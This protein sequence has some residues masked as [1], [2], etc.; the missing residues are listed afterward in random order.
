MS[1]HEKI[2]DVEVFRITNPS[3]Q[4][5][6]IKITTDEG[7]IGLGDCGVSY[8]VGAASMAHLIGEL[9]QKY[10]LGRR[11]RE[12]GLISMEMTYN[13]FW[14][15]R[16][17]SL[18]SG[19][20][21]ALDQ[22]VHDAAARS[23]GVPL[24]ELLGGAVRERVDVYANGW[25]FGQPDEA[26]QMQGALRAVEDGHTGLK[27][28][29]FA[30]QDGHQRLIHPL[31]SSF[32]RKLIEESVGRVE[33][34]R[35]TVGDEVQIMVDLSG[36]MP[37]D[38]SVNV[39]QEFADLGV[40]FAEEPFNPSDDPSHRWLAGRS[41]LPIAAGERFCG[42]AAFER[43]IESGGVDI[44]Q[45]D[46]S[47][48]GGHRIFQAVADLALNRSVRVSPHNCSSGIST[49]HTLQ[50]VATVSNLHSVE[51]FPYLDSDPNYV[52]IL[53]DPLELRI[54]AGSLAI[55]QSPG[56]GVDFD[57]KRV[58]PYRVLHLRA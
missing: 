41:P 33:A 40:D 53:S 11:L 34:L 35:S 6:V 21:S 46:I 15:K 56:I 57:E 7:T 19:A 44:L 2:I 37:R 17:G 27:L 49:A 26:A 38:I 36:S 8:G 54:D 3:L 16:A 12:R 25:Y 39:L 48:I 22:A 23:L 10:V 52:E 42:V 45:P 51:T 32:G 30:V 24:F 47:L 55:P 9:A 20:I 4:P 18:I 1:L 13:S 28:Y 58:E 50:A 31:P 5:T 14:A 29:P 43:A